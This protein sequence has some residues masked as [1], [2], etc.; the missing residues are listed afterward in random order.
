MP[1]DLGPLDH[2]R[3]GTGKLSLDAPLKRQ[4]LTPDRFIQ[5]PKWLLAAQN[6][7]FVT[8]GLQELQV[9]GEVLAVLVTDIPVFHGRIYQKRQNDWPRGPFQGFPRPFRLLWT[10]WHTPCNVLISSNKRDPSAVS[11]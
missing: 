8:S 2:L 11:G 10:F 4:F 6:H 1:S 9:G 3:H 5:S 7:R